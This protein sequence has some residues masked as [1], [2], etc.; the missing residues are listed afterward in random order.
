MLIFSAGASPAK[1][2]KP[3]ADPAEQQKLDA[4]LTKFDETQSQTRTLTATFTERKEIAL[5]KEPVV[6]KGRFYYTKPDDVLWQYTDPDPRYFLI[7]KDEL[8]S[9][10]P[11]KHK[12]E[13]VSIRM[14]HDRL[15]KVLAIGQ[16][17]QTLRKYYDIRLEDSNT[18][19]NTNLLVLSPRKRMVKKRISE[20][21]LW[22]GKDTALPLRM[23]YREPDGDSTTIAFEDVRFNPQIASS[24]YKIEIPKDV[25]IKK[26]FS[27]MTESKDKDQG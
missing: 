3:A 19:P 16:P 17:S 5:L 27:G 8:L 14:Y 4:I 15:L 12:A 9:Y 25:E 10:F 13:R 23:Q 22:V 7:S 1:D 2:K 18:V 26:G 20:I 24:V 6:A 21:R 11:T